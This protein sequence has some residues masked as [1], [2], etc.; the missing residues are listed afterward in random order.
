M[1]DAV[2]KETLVTEESITGGYYK[3]KQLLRNQDHKK[4][5]FFVDSPELH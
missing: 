1:L 3:L 5:N 2:L 4:I